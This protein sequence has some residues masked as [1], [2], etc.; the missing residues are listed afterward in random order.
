MGEVVVIT[1]GKGGVGKTTTTANLGS[2]LARMGKSVV[3]VDG[4]IGLR[5]LDVL[6]GMDNKVVYDL[7]DVVKGKCRLRQAILSDSRYPKLHLIAAS[8]TQEKRDVEPAEMQ[9]LCEELRTQYD[10]VL[11]DCPAG[12]EHGFINAVYG[13]DRAV[14]VTTPENASLR[15]ADKI[16]SMLD[17]VKELPKHLLIN[18]V[19]PLMAR[20]GFAPST[21]DIVEMLA[22]PL[23]GIV[24]D[25]THVLIANN[26]GTAV[27]ENPKSMAGKAFQNA[28]RRLLG[29]TVPPLKLREK[30][31]WSVRVKRLFKKKT[32]TY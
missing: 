15:D 4:D 19:Q 3:L 7:V 27:A 23:I 18:R 30:Q 28:A 22:I 8:Q 29:E 13:A 26:A 25:D 24:P 2:A 11:I 17:S 16:I 10:F 21:A 32:A 31:K 9:A 1:S 14:V 12:I 6:T 20:N 5:N